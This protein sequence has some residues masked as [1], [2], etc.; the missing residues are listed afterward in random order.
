[1]KFRNF[2]I[3]IIFMA[4]LFLGVF[5]LSKP[6]GRILK[7]ET[8]VETKLPKTFELQ[9]EEKNKKRIELVFNELKRALLYDFENE[10]YERMGLLLAEQGTVIYEGKK[11]I[12]G[13][14]GIKDFFSN[15]GKGRGIKIEFENAGPYRMIEAVINGYEVNKLAIVDFRISL[16]KPEGS[17]GGQEMSYEC[18]MLLFHRKICW[19]DG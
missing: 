15:I 14:D 8:S 1:M 6:A 3:L 10:Q 9:D 12:S 5:C 11:R 4:A 16:G 13:V 17:N 7:A 2:A 19:P 18:D